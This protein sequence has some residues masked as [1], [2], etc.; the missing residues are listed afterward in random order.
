[1]SIDSS[2][3]P[4]IEEL[5]P[6]CKYRINRC[7][8]IAEIRWVKLSIGNAQMT[9]VL[10]NKLRGLFM[11][12]QTTRNC[13]RAKNERSKSGGPRE[14][15]INYHRNSSLQKN[16]HVISLTFTFV[17]LLVTSQQPVAH[18]KSHHCTLFGPQE[19][20]LLWP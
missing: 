7:L 2:A 3:L 19:L 15:V 5:E 12:Y 13:N 9:P 10:R 14:N 18:N 20:S 17:N 11:N 6:I 1:M 4:R 8:I 16:F